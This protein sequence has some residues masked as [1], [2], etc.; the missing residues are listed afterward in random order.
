MILKIA[1]PFMLICSVSQA[2]QITP[3]V[4]NATGNSAAIL[5]TTIEWNVGE[6]IISTM[7][8]SNGVWIGPFSKVS[9][10]NSFLKS[11]EI[12]VTTSK[13]CNCLK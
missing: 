13:K 1:V 11:T 10:A 4:I 9:Q 3:S 8:A 5:N 6:S 7:Q 12:I 2:Q